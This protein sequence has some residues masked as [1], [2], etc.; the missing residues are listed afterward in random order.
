MI[1]A[2]PHL[3]HSS[4]HSV[5]LHT[6]T[7]RNLA[8]LQYDVGEG[9]RLRNRS[10]QQNTAPQFSLP[11]TLRIGGAVLSFSETQWVRQGQCLGQTCDVHS[12]QEMLDCA[13]G[14]L[15]PWT[16]LPKEAV[17][18]PPPETFKS[19]PDMFLCDLP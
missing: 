3:S 11:F 17:K 8:I 2:S 16:R 14:V 4:H 15:R 19:C 7:G 12:L 9:K 5:L 10:W 6:L 1:L 13:V 18:S